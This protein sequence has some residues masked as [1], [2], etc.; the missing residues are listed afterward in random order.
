MAAFKCWIHRLNKLPLNEINEHKELNTNIMIA[1][2]KG[3]LEQIILM[4]N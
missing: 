1:Q 4:L 3:Y 2:H